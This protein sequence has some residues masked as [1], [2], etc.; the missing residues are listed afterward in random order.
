MF[1]VGKILELVGDETQKPL[2]PEWVDFE[3]VFSSFSKILRF[4]L[5]CFSFFFSVFIFFLLFV[6]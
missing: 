6:P 5:C 3:E 1:F 4:K 2:D